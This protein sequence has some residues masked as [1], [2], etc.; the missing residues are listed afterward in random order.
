MYI[1]PGGVADAE[2]A[3]IP[4]TRNTHARRYANCGAG[5]WVIDLVANRLC[6]AYMIGGP[7]R[8]A[9]IDRLRSE[10]CEQLIDQGC[11]SEYFRNRTAI[12]D[13][14]NRATFRSV[15]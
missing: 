10:L 13:D 1:V 12:V 11:F 4:A 3:K 7:L 2:F 15:E 8:G 14:G 9:I 6:G 5:R